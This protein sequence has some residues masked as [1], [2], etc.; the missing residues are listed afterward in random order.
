MQKAPGRDRTL[1]SEPQK[2]GRPTTRHYLASNVNSMRLRNVGL[3]CMCSLGG[4]TCGPQGVRPAR[5]FPPDF[6]PVFDWWSPRER[7]GGPQ[8]STASSCVGR[9]KKTTASEEV[10]KPSTASDR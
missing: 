3:D 5:V 7:L 6:G 4:C 1:L 8:R 10:V 2:Q 9:S